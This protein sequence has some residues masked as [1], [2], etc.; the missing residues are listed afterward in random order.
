[1]SLESQG[2]VITAWILP[3]ATDTIGCMYLCEQ[4]LSFPLPNNSQPKLPLL[5]FWRL[6][7]GKCV[8]MVL[9][10]DSISASWDVDFCYSVF[11]IKYLTCCIFDTF[12]VFL[13]HCGSD[14]KLGPVHDWCLY[15]FVD[16]LLKTA[17]CMTLFIALYFCLVLAR[18]KSF[19]LFLLGLW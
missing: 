4:M 11:G 14:S 15:Y 13:W 10:L 2:S 7:L 18:N 6:S 12:P 19:C 16:I 5:W 17:E 9:L 8:W 3:Y 1:M